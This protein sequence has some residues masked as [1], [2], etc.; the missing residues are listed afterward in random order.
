MIFHKNWQEIIELLNGLRVIQS[1]NRFVQMKAGWG[2]F[3]PDRFAAQRTLLCSKEVL[4]PLKFQKPFDA[5]SC[6]G[7]Q[8]NKFLFWPPLTTAHKENHLDWAKKYIKTNF[9][10]I[11]FTDE[12]CTPLHGPD[13]WSSGWSVNGH[14]VPTRCQHGG[15]GVIIWA[16]LLENKMASPFRDIFLKICGVPYW[17]S[18]ARV[19]NEDPCIR[20]KNNFMQNNAAVHAAKNT[21][22]S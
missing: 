3:Q 20:E 4:E 22:D 18:P 17:L 12:C 21:I 1:T 10:A 7:L 5:A 6:R 13:G 2:K 11:L 14:N 16:G 15:G 9:Q 8:T 19:R